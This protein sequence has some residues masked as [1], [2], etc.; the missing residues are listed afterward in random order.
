MQEKW[1]NWAQLW[2]IWRNMCACMWSWCTCRGQRTP[3][4]LWFSLLLCGVREQTRVT[5]LSGQALLLAEP[6]RNF[7]IIPKSIAKSKQ[8]QSVHSFTGWNWSWMHFSSRSWQPLKGL[9]DCSCLSFPE[10][11]QGI[12]IPE[13]ESESCSSNRWQLTTSSTK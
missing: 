2:K 3:L 6:R 5:R 9:R 13:T 12:S 1:E 8:M 7:Y 4:W 11:L 10:L